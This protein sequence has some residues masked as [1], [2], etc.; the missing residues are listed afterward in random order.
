MADA[1]QTVSIRQ[2]QFLGRVVGPHVQI[3]GYVD[4]K[5]K[6][7]DGDYHIRLIDPATPED[8]VICEVIPALPMPNGIPVLHTT[9]TIW[10]IARFDSEHGWPELHP[11]LG[12]ENATQ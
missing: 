7:A 6:E 1:Y 8:F 10:G 11:V 12:W 4:Y 5:S 2:M 9:V 3:T